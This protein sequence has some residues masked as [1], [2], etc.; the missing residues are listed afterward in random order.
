MTTSLALLLS[1]LL[2][3]IGAILEILLQIFITRELGVKGYG[4]YSA[5]I[6]AADLIFWVLFSGI[7]KCNT[8]YLS[9]GNCTIRSFKQKYYGKY[10]LPAV[11]I[12]AA[13]MAGVTRNP[14]VCMIICITCLELAV[15]DQ[16]STLLAR[17]RVQQSLIGEYVLGRF[18][19]LISVFLLGKIGKLNL[20]ILLV[21]YLFQ[22][23]CVI[24][25]FA[26]RKTKKSVSKTDIS[27]TVSIK[28]W[29]AYQWADLMYSMISQM[30]VV[31]QYFFSGAFEAGV[32]SIVLLVKK[33]INFI[34]GPTAKIFL[35][36]FSRM[37]RGGQDKEIREYY[38]SIMRLQ[39][40]FVG[41]LAV[42]L[43]GFPKAVLKILAYELIGYAD[44]FVLCAFIFLLTATLGPCGGI[45]QMTGNEKTDNRCRE[46]S[47][48]IMAAAMVIFRHDKLFV[49]YG[50]C[51]Q[52]ASEAIGK[53]L[54][55]CRWMK[56]PPVR[57]T[58]YLKWWI[59][60]G[61]V[62]V[63]VRLSE[64]ENSYIWMLIFAGMVF[65][66]EGMNEIRGNHMLSVIGKKLK[67]TK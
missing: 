66:I 5:W 53:Y 44:L 38:A 18:I 21:L 41:P 61:I 52:S 14:F 62:I 49:L 67:V 19:L 33:L 58:T 25:F 42:V 56:K 6:N 12:M 24:A 1:I 9:G 50:L 32:V 3:G 15:F 59:I 36:E 37:Y 51:I 48:L 64:I 60:P 28:K 57:M 29:G 46:I 39:M 31:L 65:A 30:P 22:Y 8:F 47:L 11:T 63:G 20:K 2:K 40:I 10:V 34:S 13:I 27:E 7:V 45:M 4:N 17:G 54:F 26:F 35:P 23:I 55:V 16:S 43:L